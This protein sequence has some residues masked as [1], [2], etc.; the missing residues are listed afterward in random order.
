MSAHRFGPP[1]LLSA[2][3][4]T[5]AYGLFVLLFALDVFI[6]GRPVGAVIIEF[7]IHAAPTFALFFCLAISWRSPRLAGILVLACALFFTLLFQTY[8]NWFLFL[9][10]SGTLLVSGALLLLHA[11][12]ASERN[13]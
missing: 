2:R 8:R 9:V 12:S 5:I 1:L 7:I 13:T 4:L 10:F 6:P 11:R 3:L